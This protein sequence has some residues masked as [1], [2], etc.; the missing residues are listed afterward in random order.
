M[1]LYPAE[2][3]NFNKPIVIGDELSDF[4]WLEFEDAAKIIKKQYKA[5]FE[6]MNEYILL[7]KIVLTWPVNETLVKIKNAMLQIDIIL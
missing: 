3:T 6:S 7:N 4:K 5:A 1:R 2:L